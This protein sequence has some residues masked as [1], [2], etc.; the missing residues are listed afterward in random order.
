MP[1]R[2]LFNLFLGYK[3]P[4]NIQLALLA[5]SLAFIETVMDEYPFV[6]LQIFAEL[7][8]F[9][10]TLVLGIADMRVSHLAC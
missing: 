2:F 8:Y 4:I 3:Y 1:R 10:L 5:I 9:E 7:P 6:A